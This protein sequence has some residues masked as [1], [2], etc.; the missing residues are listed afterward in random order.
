MGEF[1]VKLQ[2]ELESRRRTL[3]PG[4]ADRCLW[5][6]VKRRVHLYRVE[7]LGVVSQL[8]EAPGTL[9]RIEHAVPRAS[10][11]RIV[12]ARGANPENARHIELVFLHSYAKNT[13]CVKM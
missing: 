10:T 5:L 7:V 8:V 11:R 1:S 4:T 13:F 6:A 9:R 3:D 2:R 12:P